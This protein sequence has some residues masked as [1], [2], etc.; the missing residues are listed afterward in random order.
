MLLV[1]LFQQLSHKKRLSPVPALPQGSPGASQSTS[2][3][4]QCLGRRH[5]CLQG[6]HRHRREVQRDAD[7]IGQP[8]DAT[9]TTSAGGH[10]KAWNAAP[11]ASSASFSRFSCELPKKY[12]LEA[13]LSAV[14]RHPTPSASA[15]EASARSLSKA[16]RSKPGPCGPRRAIDEALRRLGPLPAAFLLHHDISSL[17]PPAAHHGLR[18][19]DSL[20]PHSHEF[21]FLSAFQTLQLQYIAYTVYHILSYYEYIYI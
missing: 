19:S 5:V 8:G 10:R 17:G 9:R 14:S 21:L 2:H 6:Y 13:P 12:A 1:D 16:F 11:S 7:L 3:D 15:L 20:K 4:F 18:P